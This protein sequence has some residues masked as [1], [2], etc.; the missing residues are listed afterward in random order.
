MKPIM[1]A[2]TGIV[3]GAGPA[4]ASGSQGVSDA[5]LLVWLFLGLGA[6]IIAFQFLPGLV[7]FCS[8][9]KGLFGDTVTKSASHKGAEIS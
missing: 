7:L 9:I 3:A 8:M 1:T 5:G 4:M 2:V 6:L